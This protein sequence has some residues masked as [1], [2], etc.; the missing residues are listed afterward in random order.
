MVGILIKISL[1]VGLQ[2]P[3][4]QMRFSGR[5]LHVVYGDIWMCFVPE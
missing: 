2:L 3:W 5:T 1:S 4:K